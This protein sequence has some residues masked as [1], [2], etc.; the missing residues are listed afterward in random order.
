MSNEIIGAPDFMAMV[1][2]IKIPHAKPGAFDGKRLGS[3]G[4]CAG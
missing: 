2:F 3:E 1:L 4:E